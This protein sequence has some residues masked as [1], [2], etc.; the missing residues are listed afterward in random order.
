[1]NPQVGLIACDEYNLNRL[2]DA[3]IRAIECAGFNLALL[4]GKSVLLKPNLLMPIVPERAVTTH[5]VFFHA[6][7]EIVRDYA[8]KL[9]VVD[10]PNF[11][12]LSSAMKKSGLMEVAQQLNI[13]IADNTS[14]RTLHWDGGRRYRTHEISSI[15]FEADAIINLPK[16]KSHSLTRLTG[17]VKNL[18][19][20][21]P[22]TKKAQ[23]HMKVPDPVEFSEYLLDLYG[24]L[25]F[26]F[27]T[28]K[29]ILHLMDAVVGLEGEGPGPSG[30][31]KKI[32]AVIAGT[33]AVAVDF[34]AAKL[35][36]LDIN[37]IFTITRSYE[38]PFGI[39]SPD[40]IVIAGDDIEKLKI[41]DFVPSKTS[42]LKSGFW[43]SISPAL[44]NLFVER[45]VPVEEKCTMCLYCKNVCPAGAISEK[46]GRKVPFFD[47]KKCIRCFCCLETCPGEAIVLKKGLLQWSRG[48]CQQ[49]VE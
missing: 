27:E 1:M 28:P 7:A 35:V 24:A 42:V 14:T 6:V 18:F 15:F 4:R 29:I 47:S 37:E 17:A 36:N 43:R 11:F 34:T 9:T 22:G 13:D 19:G 41:Y 38:R 45:P 46:K 26:G 16:L 25:L 5:P 3:I 8:R 23:M 21:I 2:K 10:S 32:G 31:P 30:K 48:F 40:D 20:A 39:G 33:D 44:K 49:A 12:A